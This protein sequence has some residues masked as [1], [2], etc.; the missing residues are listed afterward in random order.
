MC[1]GGGSV[2][3]K[4]EEGEEALVGRERKLREIGR[5]EELKEGHQLTCVVAVEVSSS[6]SCEREP[7]GRRGGAS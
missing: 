7:T 4:E 3:R 1:A 6:V 2:H 5:E